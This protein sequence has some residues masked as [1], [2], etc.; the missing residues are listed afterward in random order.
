VF[1]TGVAKISVF[2]DAGQLSAPLI[3]FNRFF[4]RYK[5]V[6]NSL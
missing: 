1:A 6:I 5:F 4:T 3:P 2:T